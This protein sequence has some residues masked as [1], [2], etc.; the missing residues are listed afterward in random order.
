MCRGDSSE[1]EKQ[2]IVWGASVG[3]GGWVGVWRTVGM[4][5]R[6]NG[7]EVGKSGG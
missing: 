7:D 2:R 1:I 4:Q 6:C 3:G 5:V